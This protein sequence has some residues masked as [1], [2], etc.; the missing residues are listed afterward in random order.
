MMKEA[1]IV[2]CNKGNENFPI[3]IP[4]CTRWDCPPDGRDTEMQS[5]SVNFSPR[6]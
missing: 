4:E 6:S 2:F 5:L 1:R 3:T